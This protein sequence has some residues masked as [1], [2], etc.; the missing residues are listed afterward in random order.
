[1]LKKMLDKQRD[2]RDIICVFIL[3]DCQRTCQ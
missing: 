2:R 1:M 3:V